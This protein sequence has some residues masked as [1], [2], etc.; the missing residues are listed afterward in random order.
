MTC[1]KTASESA[2][3]AL[4]E[5]HEQDPAQHEDAEGRE[6]A[7]MILQRAVRDVAAAAHAAPGRML[8][9]GAVGRRCGV[10]GGS[11]HALCTRAMRRRATTRTVKVTRNRMQP[12]AI[13]ALS[14]RPTASLNSLAMR[15]AMVEP[16]SKIESD[17]RLALPITKVTAMVSPSAR[18]SPSMIAPMMLTPGLR[19]EHVAD[20][21]PGRAAD[22][23]GALAQH[24]SGSGRGCRG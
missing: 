10:H 5:Q 16:G 22:A 2:A 18:P 9:G 4:D 21:L 7:Q 19:H 3:D 1:V 11:S 8:D 23:V 15:E 17:R 12:S 24:R 14:C 20:D 6:H 13:S